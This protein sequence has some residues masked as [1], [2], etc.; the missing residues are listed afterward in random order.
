MPRRYAITAEPYFSSMRRPVLDSICDGGPQLKSAN[1]GCTSRAHN[2]AAT[3][4]SDTRSAK[5]QDI[6][7]RR[8]LLFPRATV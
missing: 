4:T 3:T 8:A 6:K 2:V 1:Q 7:P 5:E